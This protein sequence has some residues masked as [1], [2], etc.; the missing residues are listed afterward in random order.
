MIDAG[1]FPHRDAPGQWL[2][3]VEGWLDELRG[4]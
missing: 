2:A 1:H 3:A 4:V